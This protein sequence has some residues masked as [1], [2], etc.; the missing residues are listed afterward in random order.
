MSSLRS[1]E[2]LVHGH[3]LL[4]QY[5]HDWQNLKPLHARC[6]I[7]LESSQRA[8]GLSSIRVARRVFDDSCRVA[9]HDL[10]RRHVLGNSS[11]SP[12]YSVNSATQFI[13]PTYLGHNTPSSHSR[14][15][16]D[17]HPR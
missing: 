3:I 6:L 9:C 16:S 17:P 1:I 4:I 2:V 14:A 13:G 11:V 5:M 7:P 12:C 10:V 8:T 15:L